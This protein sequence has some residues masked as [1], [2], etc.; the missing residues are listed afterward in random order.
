MLTSSIIQDP[1][2]RGILIVEDDD[3]TRFLIEGLLT[4]EG[5]D[6]IFQA[7]DGAEALSVLEA[8]APTVYLILLDLVMPKMSGLEVVRHVANVH[9]YPVGI[10]VVTGYPSY[11]ACREFYHLGTDNVLALNFIPKPFDAKLLIREVAETLD[12]VQTKRLNQPLAAAGDLHTRFDA[13]EAKLTRVGQEVLGRLEAID[14]KLGPMSELPL[15]REKL[16]EVS[17]KQPSFLEQI[18]MD[19]VRAVLIA[20]AFLA[21]LYAG[22]GD[23]LARVLRK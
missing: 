19:V 17:R 14:A 11:D 5:Y 18:G 1:K 7:C 10:V 23:F 8:H 6:T 20:L 3:G 9:K 4:H 16:S 12:Q 2:Q 13:V 15:F 21:L 22:I